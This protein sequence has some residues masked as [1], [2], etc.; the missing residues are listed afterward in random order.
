MNFNLRVASDCEKHSSN[1]D[2]KYNADE[3]SVYNF[4]EFSIIPSSGQIPAQ[5]SIKLAIEFIP[6]FIKKY[7]TALLLDIDDIGLSELFSLPITARSTVP[8]IT[9][10]TSMIDLG[11]CF[12][13]H[14]YESSIKLTND[15]CLKARYQLIPSAEE[16]A[17]K[18]TSIQ[19]EVC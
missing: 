9:I 17:I 14:G 10:T 5:S 2:E 7:E 18:F 1:L 8:Q 19:S 4:K 11:R 12:I 13:Y 6:R 16:D 15:S 3:N